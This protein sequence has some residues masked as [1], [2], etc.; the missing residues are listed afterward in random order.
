MLSSFLSPR[1]RL[2]S[3]TLVTLDQLSCTICPVSI[4]HT[5][6]Y[7]QPL[8]KRLCPKKQWVFINL[9][10]NQNKNWEWQERKGRGAEKMDDKCFPTKDQFSHEQHWI[11]NRVMHEADNLFTSLVD[12]WSALCICDACYLNNIC[13]WWSTLLSV[14]VCVYVVAA[15]LWA[16]GW[17][18]WPWKQ[19]VLAI[20]SP[21]HQ[22]DNTYE[23]THIH[24]FTS[25]QR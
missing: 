8:A 25:H 24:T 13:A 20:K 6:I 14:C 1:H 2:W 21:G 18:D 22:P 7:T 4:Q 10:Q 3:H 9:C 5:L 15:F 23:H 16:V 17:K 11:W 12:C 19:T